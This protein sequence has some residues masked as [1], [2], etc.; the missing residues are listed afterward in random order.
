MK[1]DL[2]IAGFPLE[3]TLNPRPKL[4]I[5]AV[6]FSENP[7]SLG[8]RLVNH[9]IY[10]TPSDKFGIKFRNIFQHN[11]VR[12][13]S[14]KESHLWL[15][16]PNMSY[17]PQQLNFA[18]W[19]A[20]AGCGISIRSLFDDGMTDSELK[21]P[22]QVRSFLWFHV[23]FTVRRILFEMGGIQGPV[24]LP[25]DPVFDVIK[26]SYDISSYKRICNEFKIAPNSDFR[27]KKG[28]NNG[29]GDV[30]VW[31]TGL[32]PTNTD[33]RY[34]DWNKF[35]DEGGKAIEGDLI[36]YIDNG[37]AR[38]Q[39]EYFVTPVSYGLTSAGQ[40]RINQSIEAFV[41]CI[42]G[43]HINVRSSIIGTSGSAK[44]VGREF[45]TLIEDAI[46]QPDISKSVQRFQLVVQEA[47][48]KLDLAISP[49]TW[50]M[51]SRMVINTESKVNYNNKLKKA[52]SSM[53]LGV[54]R[55]HNRGRRP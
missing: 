55:S 7:H 20:T 46:A 28:S 52:N 50:L 36:Y 33:Y 8:D 11:I 31:A 23:Y 53:K 16:G 27:F 4:S 3:L 41:Y 44:E 49:G 25:D 35:S 19:C 29:L 32:G 14:G 6:E 1:K 34:P 30:Y 13:T 47:K 9:D 18:V 39:Y 5:P 37:L 54:N 51:P 22:P 12:H 24:P 45:L 43:S 40:T 21:L 38:H 17:W 26:N 48:G 10:L 2:S 15:K 42:L